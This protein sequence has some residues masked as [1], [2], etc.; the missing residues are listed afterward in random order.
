MEEAMSWLS[1]QMYRPGGEEIDTSKYDLLKSLLS[2]VK[3]GT[4][5]AEAQV[6]NVNALGAALDARAGKL[7]PFLLSLK[8]GKEALDAAFPLAATPWAAGLMLEAGADV[9]SEPPGMSTAIVNA[10]SRYDRGMVDFLVAHGARL[11]GDGKAVEKL[12][13][14]R[15]AERK[16]RALGML[17][18]LLERGATPDA[19]LSSLGVRSEEDLQAAQEKY[20]DVFQVFEDCKAECRVPGSRRVGGEMAGD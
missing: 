1:R 16:A 7:I 17:R 9:N 6:G 4:P 2:E 3:N 10:A 15:L 12:L 19:W 13:T 18:F 5:V 8:P 11:R 20:P 14:M